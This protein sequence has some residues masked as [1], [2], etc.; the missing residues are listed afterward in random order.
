MIQGIL[1][2]SGKPGLYR[3]VSRGKN[4]LIVENLQT[5]KRMPVYAHDKVI[6][7]ADIAIYTEG[8]DMPLGEVLEK[9]KVATDGQPVDVKKFGSDEE[10]REYFGTILPEF[11]RDRV[12]TTDIRK[13]FSWYNIMIASG[14]TEFKKEDIAEDE[15][16]EAAEAADAAETTQE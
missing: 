14:V 6:S 10:L 2:I 12:Y 9:V 13:L 8:E 11:D 5:G 1:S 16:A 4:T 7:L 3:L 15:A